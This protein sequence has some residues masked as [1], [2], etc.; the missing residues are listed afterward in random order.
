M[1]N[2][3]QC[4]SHVSDIDLLRDTSQKKNTSKLS[5]K[6]RFIT[7]SPII[8][9]IRTALFSKDNV[10]RVRPVRS[11][12]LKSFSCHLTPEIPKSRPNAKSS[13]NSESTLALQSASSECTT[14][15]E[16][17]DEQL[18]KEQN[19]DQ[20]LP[21]SISN[22][23]REFSVDS[24]NEHDHIQKLLEQSKFSC[25]PDI[26][27]VLVPIKNS[28]VDIYSKLTNLLHRLEN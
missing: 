18:L 4:S 22:N 8:H 24:L 27:S 1:S 17:L 25:F 26:F 19:I 14:Y 13:E 10:K 6:S 20:D 23:T 3:V 16:S 11:E 15:T 5:D 21:S 28:C 2:V 7:S 9:N 12:E